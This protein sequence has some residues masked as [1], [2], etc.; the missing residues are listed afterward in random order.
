[1]ECV[2]REEPCCSLVRTAHARTCMPRQQTK[3]ARHCNTCI[4]SAAWARRLGRVSRGK[5]QSVDRCPVTN[6]CTA[7]C[8]AAWYFRSPPS[9]RCSNNTACRYM[10]V[11]PPTAAFSFLHLCFSLPFRICC[12]TLTNINP[13]QKGNAWKFLI[14]HH[15][16][17]IFDWLSFI[18]P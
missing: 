6:I 16:P 18:C 5:P 14:F 2:A 8:H 10:L 4:T 7:R 3:A 1:M 9:S 12:E 13:K 17:I 11:L 15:F